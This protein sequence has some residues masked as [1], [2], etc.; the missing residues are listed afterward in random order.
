M[1]C[2]LVATV[3]ATEER[4]VIGQQQSD[5]SNDVRKLATPAGIYLFIYFIIYLF[6]GYFIHRMTDLEL[7]V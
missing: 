5:V 2:V 4:D 3:S 1:A 7:I 6:L